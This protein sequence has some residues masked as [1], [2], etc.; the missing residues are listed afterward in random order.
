MCRTTALG[1]TRVIILM[2][3][4]PVMIRTG[5]PP[6]MTRTGRPHA[7]IMVEARMQVQGRRVR[8]LD[9]LAYVPR[10]DQDSR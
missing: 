7:M 4:P 3:G 10:V 9:C 6:I 5:R 1:H 2:G 8:R